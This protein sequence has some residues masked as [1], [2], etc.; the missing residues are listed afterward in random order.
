MHRFN[1]GF[2][3]RDVH[4]MMRMNEARAAAEDALRE[5]RRSRRSFRQSLAGS[6]VAFAERLAP[7]D[8]ATRSGTTQDKGD[9]F[10]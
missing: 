10:P 9:G 1:E 3:L 6:L 8:Y 2:M 5:L 7:S 4:R